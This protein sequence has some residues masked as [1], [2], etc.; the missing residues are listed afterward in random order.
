MSKQQIEL[1]CEVR[2]KTG[3]AW[4]IYDGDKEAWIP[5]SQIQDYSETDGNVESIFI[6]EWMAKEKG[7]I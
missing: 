4:L 5:L 3:K 6:S 1:A 7:L 2:A